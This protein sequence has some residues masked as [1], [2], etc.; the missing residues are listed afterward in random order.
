MYCA[1]SILGIETG[2]INNR[3]R[4]IRVRLQQDCYT[5]RELRLDNHIYTVT[6]WKSTEDDDTWRANSTFTPTK[7]GQP[8]DE[9]PFTL[10]TSSRRFLPEKAKLADVC[11]VNAQHYIASSNLA[12]ADYWV[13]NP[14]PYVFGMKAETLSMGPGKFLTSETPGNE[15]KVGMLEYTGAAV[16][17]LQDRVNNLGN[18][19]AKVGSRVLAQEKAA[20]EAADAIAIKTASENAVLASTARLVSRWITDQL[21][22]VSWWLGLDEGAISFDLNT[23]YDAARLTFQDR[24]QIVAEWSAGL[25]SKDTALDQLIEGDILP[26]TFDRELDAQKMAEE[27]IDRPPVDPTVINQGT[28]PSA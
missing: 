4:V 6:I 5:I 27:M 17:Q 1:E 26:E 15:I 11:D 12:I 25:Y 14:M 3:Q 9:I 7:A 13:S 22:W 8:L 19:I 18:D 23:S 2:V 20:V 16:T 28:Q 21:K 24:A 10:V